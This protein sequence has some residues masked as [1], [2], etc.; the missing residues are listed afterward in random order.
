MRH[1]AVH[2]I[3]VKTTDPLPVGTPG[4]WARTVR[5]HGPPGITAQAQLLHGRRSIMSR[6]WCQQGQSG[7]HYVVPLTRDLEE[8]EADAIAQAWADAWP[9]GDFVINWTQRAVAQRT[10][11]TQQTA[12]LREIADTA[13]RQYHRQWMD[14]KVKEGWNFGH[15]LDSR[16]RKHPMLQPWANLPDAYKT[17]E[18]DR[19]IT[20]LQVLESLDLD[21]KRR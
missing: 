15:S 2:S 18:R 11:D 19:F 12:V 4:L 20:L 9:Q 17:Q 21:I 5:D 10:A 13:A 8:H 1:T 7:Y 14:H 6:L 16:Q 3:E